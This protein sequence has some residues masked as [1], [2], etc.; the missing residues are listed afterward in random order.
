MQFTQSFLV[1]LLAIIS[2]SWLTMAQDPISGINRRLIN[3]GL[4]DNIHLDNDHHDDNQDNS[5]SV[6][7]GESVINGHTL[8]DG[9]N[10][11]DGKTYTKTKGFIIGPSITNGPGFQLSPQVTNAF[12]CMKAGNSVQMGDCK[13]VQSKIDKA[14]AS[15]TGSAKSTPTP[16]KDD[17]KSSSTSTSTSTSSPFLSGMDSIFS[18]QNNAAN[19]FKSHNAEYFIFLALSVA[20]GLAIVF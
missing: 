1:I 11:I 3:P 19:S 2:C 9:V 4:V 17:S 15:V 7:N 13:D 18:R 10:T 6:T 20:A 14:L 12:G 16:S 5:V 8:K